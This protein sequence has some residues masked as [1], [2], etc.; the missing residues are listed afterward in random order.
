MKYFKKIICGNIKNYEVRKHIVKT[1]I[2]QII[3]YNDAIVFYNFT[4]LNYT[5]SAI[6]NIIDNLI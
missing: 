4:D 3:L 6:T 5:Q 1:F 2:K